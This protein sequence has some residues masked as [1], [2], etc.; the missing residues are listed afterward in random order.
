MIDLF[1][2]LSVLRKGLEL[3]CGFPGG[4]QG[5]LLAS[6]GLLTLDM[7]NKNALTSSSLFNNLDTTCIGDSEAS[8]LFPVLSLGGEMSLIA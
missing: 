7:H 3:G 1:A 2:S 6:I 4:E 5:C 8:P